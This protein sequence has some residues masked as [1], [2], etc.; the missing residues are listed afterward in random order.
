MKPR[1]RP[2][3]RAAQARFSLPQTDPLLLLAGCA[4]TGILLADFVPAGWAWAVIIVFAGSAAGSVSVRSAGL[5]TI[6]LGAAVACAFGSIHLLSTA[7]KTALP[8]FGDLSRGERLRLTGV[9]SVASVEY[10]GPA[11]TRGIATI[12]SG[13]IDGYPIGSPF[14]CAFSIPAAEVAPGQRVA[15]EGSVAL[16]PAPRNPGEYDRRSMLWRKGVAIGFQPDPG[17]EGWA[18]LGGALQLPPLQRLAL[19]GSRWAGEALT[20]GLEDE[21]ETANLLRAMV[22]GQ[23]GLTSASTKDA[24]RLSGTLHLFAVSGLHVGMLG[25]ILWAMLRPLGM[26]RRLLLYV[27]APLLFFY[28]LLSGLQPPVVRAALMFAAFLG[29]LALGR[30]P[31]I[32][33]SLGAAA[34]ILLAAG[35]DQLFLPGFQLSFGVLLAIVL[36]TPRLQAPLHRRLHTDPFLPRPLRHP[37][38]DPLY[39]WLRRG[40]AFVAVSVAAF[41]GSF[42]L[43]WIYF[44]LI[45]PASIAANCLLVPLAFLILF[46]ATLSVLCSALSLTGAG[47]LFN[48]ANHLWASLAIA[49]AR[50]CASL[51]GG[52]WSPPPP[53]SWSCPP[54]GITVLH[55]PEGGQSIHMAAGGSRHWWIDTGNASSAMGVVRPY[56]RYSG[57]RSLDAVLL[58]HNDAAHAGGFPMFTRLARPTRVLVPPWPATQG[59][60]PEALKHCAELRLPVETGA[61]GSQFT[62]D[63]NLRL[64]IL[65]PPTGSRFSPAEADDRGLVFRID[66]GNRSVLFTADA[67]FITEKWL[68]AN[69]A[70]LAADVLVCGKRKGDFPLSDEFLEAVAPDALI[71]SEGGPGPGRQGVAIYDQQ[72]C[73]AVLLRLYPDRIVLR[74]YLDPHNLRKTARW[75]VLPSLS[76]SRSKPVSG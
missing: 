54:A 63:E 31:R 18:P 69:G 73:G 33:N 71:L 8:G 67:G 60:L 42:P 45:T 2:A 70:R 52:H 44:G 59:S 34:L 16:I 50:E 62:L 53:G 61:A 11:E 32:L 27:L 68:L 3:G 37:C 17:P 41:L 66:C 35:T 24:F 9:A 7:A 64:T 47:V 38:Q 29:G 25:L 72:Q 65:H 46:C 15:L 4:A 57:I 19:A 43:A 26:P 74:P 36:L 55:L 22:L 58:T 13:S 40:V 48:N 14:P 75:T 28:A 56:L 76:H 21:P 5:A 39:A 30:R 1:A 6:S 20:R 51:P 12:W 10:G 23:R 49:S